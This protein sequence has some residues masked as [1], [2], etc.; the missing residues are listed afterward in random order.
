[1]GAVYEVI[2][3]KTASRRALKVMLPSLLYNEN[4]RARFGLEAKITGAIESDHLVRVLDAG[5][6][7]SSEMPFLVMELLRGE[8]LATLVLIQ[9]TLPREDVALYLM[10]VA[11]AL[12]RTHAANVV[13]R[14]LK[15]DN[16]FLTFRD[17]GTPCIKILD[18]GIAKA[19]EMQ[20]TGV[21]TRPMMGTPLYM[22]PE[23]MRAEKNIGP[24]ADIYALTHIAY[25]LLTGEPY[26]RNELEES[27]SPYLLAVEVLQGV[28][29][30]PSARALRR[31]KVMLPPAFDAWFLKGSA[32]KPEERFERALHAAQALVEALGVASAL[33]M[34]T[35]SFSSSP[36]DF[37][38]GAFGRSIT[39]RDERDAAGLPVSEPVPPHSH[40]AET[41]PPI[42]GEVVRKT[43]PD[44]ASSGQR[45]S[46]LP[47]LSTPAPVS[48]PAASTPTPSGRFKSS[49]EG[50]SKTPARPESPMGHTPSGIGLKKKGFQ[51]EID[52]PRAILRVKV[53][54]FWTVDDAK[55]YVEAFRQKAALLVGEPWY[56]LADISEF[57][58]Q[59]P[60][61]SAFVEQTMAF[62]VDNGMVRAANLVDSALGKMQIARLSQA[63]GLPEFSF[64]QSEQDA[65]RWLI[66]S[67]A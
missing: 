20:H 42:S 39:G 10:Q 1:M 12:E 48:K 4:L 40:S 35:P 53:W 47:P 28:Q 21:E 26:W 29:E 34:S 66:S 63:T 3:E 13:H 22:S 54:G 45:V 49:P 38:R 5:V 16:L 19:I 23:Q 51:V 14:D 67:A 2:D 24:A 30:A 61:V 55:A 31:R 7:T 11:R 57:A 9:G 15:P 44:A 25:A 27:P 41:V 58:A 33:R 65:I 46:A 43:N 56:V 52:Y 36:G 59:K 17:D 64:F 60:E 62:A 37:G 18:F 32:L 6:D 50:M 8:D